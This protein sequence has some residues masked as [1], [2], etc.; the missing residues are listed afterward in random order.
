MTK[1]EGSLLGLP[2]PD[3][4]GSSFS[5]GNIVPL[6]A[7]HQLSKDEQRVMAEW[8]KTQLVI[9]ATAARAVFGISK[10][11][12]IHQHGSLTFEEA[13]AAILAIKDKA[14]GKEHEAFMEEFTSRQIPLMAR[15]LFGAIDVSVTNIGLELHR[16]LYPEPEKPEPLSVWKRL[17]G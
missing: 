17:F 15:H 6:R 4:F 3:S 7:G 10:V 12:E 1:K 11:T 8:H 13:T 14:H 16:S 2:A 5:T 9:E